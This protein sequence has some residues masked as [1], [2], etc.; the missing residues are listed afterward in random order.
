MAGVDSGKTTLV[1]SRQALAPET[2]AASSNVVSA[3]RRFAATM[4]KTTGASVIPSTQPMPTGVAM[5]KVRF[6]SIN[7][8]SQMFKK[9]MRG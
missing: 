9:P 5:L 7:C 2:L 3:M 8:F 6:S 1:K 4:M